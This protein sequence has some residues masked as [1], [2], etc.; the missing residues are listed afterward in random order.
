MIITNYRHVCTGKVYKTSIVNTIICTYKD[1]KSM[2]EYKDI[3]RWLKL[4]TFEIFLY[5]HYNSRLSFSR[6]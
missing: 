1:Y 5:K 3:K 4:F 6:L 2:K